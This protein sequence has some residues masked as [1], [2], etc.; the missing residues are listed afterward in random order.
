MK[1][2]ALNPDHLTGHDV[3]LGQLWREAVADDSDREKVWR[4]VSVAGEVVTLVN[5]G[6]SYRYPTPGHLLSC[7]QILK[8]VDG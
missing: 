3:R 1:F 2:H 7:W 6:G 8:P 5:L 4:V